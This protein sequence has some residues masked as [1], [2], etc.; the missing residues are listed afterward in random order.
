MKTIVENNGIETV[1]TKEADD[2]LCLRVSI[3]GTK[4][5]GYYLVFR[6]DINMVKDMIEN[7][8]ES[9]Y[10]SVDNFKKQGN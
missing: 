4:K 6:G 5:D 1:V 9:F 8:S 10:K 3:G 2:P 7:V